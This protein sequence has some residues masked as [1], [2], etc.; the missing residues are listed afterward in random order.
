MKNILKFIFTTFIFVGC[1]Y[2]SDS[3]MGNAGSGGGGGDRDGGNSHGYSGSSYSYS[4]A[5]RDLSA[6]SSSNER[7]N[8]G[9]Y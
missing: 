4:E 8:S 9:R 2:K 5:M 7:N 6:L 3:F 1:A